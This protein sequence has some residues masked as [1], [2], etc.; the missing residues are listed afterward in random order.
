MSTSSEHSDELKSLFS[1]T[2][3]D[4]AP[5]DRELLAALR[6]HSAAE[7]AQSGPHA[8][9]EEPFNSELSTEYSVPPTSRPTV[10]HNSQFALRVVVAVAATA[11][12][13]MAGFFL[14]Q[15]SRSGA[16]P[17]AE[18]TFGEVMQNLARTDSYRAECLIEDRT[19]EIT[20]NRAQVMRVEQ[21]PALYTFATPEGTLEVDEAE[22]RAATTNRPYYSAKLRMLDPLSVWGLS[23]EQFAAVQPT[24]RETIA[25]REHLVYQCAF[26]AGGVGGSAEA[27][28]DV[29]TRLPTQIVLFGDNAERSTLADFRF[30]A[31]NQPLDP[32]KLKVPAT[33]T[34]DGRIGKVIDWQGNVALRPLGHTRWTPVCDKPLLR[35]GDWVRTDFQGANAVTVQLAPDTK[36]ILGPGS[37][38]ELAKPDQ[39]TLHAGFAEITPAPKADNFGGIVKLTGP[40]NAKLDVNGVTRVTASDKGLVT[41]DKEP[42]WLAAYKGAAVSESL[43]SLVATIDGRRVPLTVGYH[44]VSVEIRDQI[45]RT[46]IEESF[47]NHTGGVLEGQFHFPL[48]ADASISGFGM[49]VDGRLVEADIVEKQ[50]AREIYETILREKRDPGLLEWAGGNIFK[51]RVYPIPAHGEKRIKIVYTQVLPMRG[52]SYRY[53]YALQSDLLK[54]NPLRQLDLEVTVASTQPLASVSCPTHQTRNQLTEHAAR[55]E[56]SAQNYTPTRDFEVVVEMGSAGAASGMAAAQA[57][58]VVFIPHQRGEDGYF[59]LQLQPPLEGAW[60]RDVLPDS[61]ALHLLVL[62]DTSASMDAAARRTQAEVLASL[63]GSLAPKDRFNLAMCD[64]DCTWLFTEAQS[65]ADEKSIATARDRLAKRRSLGWTNLDRA[66]EAVAG[67]VRQ[68]SQ[69]VYLGDGIVTTGDMDGPAFASRLKQRLDGRGA[70]LHAVALSSSYDA[71]VLRGMAAIGGGSLRQVSGEIGPQQ[72]A[73]NLLAE[74]TR[75]ALKNIELTISGIQTAHVYPRVLPNL[76]AGT[77]QIVLGRYLPGP[78]E[79]SG[80]II[81]T[82]VLE[83]Q[84]VTYRTELRVQGSGFRVQGPDARGQEPGARGQEPGARNQ[85]IVSATPH[86]AIRTPQ[87]SDSSFIPRLWARMHLDELLAQGTTQEIQDEII[88]LSEEF[89]I[90]TPYTSLLVLES[91]AD[92]ERFKVKR[93][94]QIRDGERFF[95][96]ARDTAQYQLMQQQMQRAGLWRRGL[97]EQVLM[98]LANFGRDAEQIATIERREHLVKELAHLTD[99]ISN[100][101]MQQTSNGPLDMGLYDVELGVKIAAVEDS[102]GGL[103]LG[104]GAGGVAGSTIARGFQTGDWDENGMPEG[105]LLISDAA[106]AVDMPP[107]YAPVPSRHVA[108]E[109]AEGIPS[110]F[111]APTD[112]TIAVEGKLPWATFETSRRK[113]Q[114]AGDAIDLDGDF[115][116]RGEPDAPGWGTWG[117]LS[118][119]TSAGRSVRRPSRGTDALMKRLW[120]YEEGYLSEQSRLAPLLP[121]GLAPARAASKPVD[122]KSRWPAEAQE[123][124]RSLVTAVDLTRLDGGL[125][126]EEETRSFHPHHGRLTSLTTHSRLASSKAWFTRSEADGYDPHLEWARGEERGAASLAYGVELVR[127]A[128]PTDFPS[129][130]E[131]SQWWQAGIEWSFQDHTVEMKRPQEGQ[132]ELALKHPVQTYREVRIAIDAAKKVVLSAQWLQRGKVETTAKASDFIEIAGVWLPR[133]I[134]SLDDRGRTTST[135]TRKFTLVSVEQLAEKMTAGLAPQAAALRVRLRLP[136][137]K[138]AKDKIALG[139][140]GLE[141]RLVLLASLALDQKW[142]EAHAELA[143][144][145]PLVAD[146]SF[147]KWLRIWLLEHSRRNE[148]LRQAVAAE[149]AKLAENPASGERTLLERLRSLASSKFSYEEQLTV[150]DALKPVYARLPEHVEGPRLWGEIRQ[151]ILQNAGRDAEQLALL[152]ELVRDY[153]AED[154]HYRILAR[155]LIEQGEYDAGYA[156]LQDALARAGANWSP[157]ERDL[158]YEAW[159]DHLKEQGRWADVAAVTAEWLKHHPEDSDA[160]ERHIASLVYTRREGEA[161]ALVAAWLKAGLDASPLPKHVEAQVV[162]AV[163]TATGDNSYMSSGEVDPRSLAAMAQ[164][165]LAHAADDEEP[166]FLSH[167]SSDYEVRRT[168]EYRAAAAKLLARLKAE[169][170]TLPLVQLQQL[171]AW[172]TAYAEQATDEDW[173]AIAAA[174]KPRWQAASGAE[175]HP[176]IEQ[177]LA[178]ALLQVFGELGHS[179]RTRFLRERLAASDDERR[180]GRASALFHALLDDAWSAENEAESLALIDKLSAS[181]D[182]AERLREAVAALYRWTDRMESARYATLEAAIER[183]DKLT[184]TELAA[185]HTELRKRVLSDLADRLGRS[186]ALPAQAAAPL[187]ARDSGLARWLAIERLTLEARLERELAKV[188]ENAWELL[189]PVPAAARTAEQPLMT[190]D[191]LDAAFRARTLAMLM[192]LAI[193]TAAPAA[194]AERLAKYLDAAIAAEK[195]GAAGIDARLAKYVLLVALDKPQPLAEQ[196]AIWSKGTDRSEFWQRT[197]GYLKA[198]L[199]DLDG[200][201]GLFEPLAAA[202]WLEAADYR[203]L[204]GWHQVKRHDEKYQAAHLAAWK[205]MNEYQLRQV[206]RSHVAQWENSQGPSPGAIDPQLL[207]VL[208]ALFA[209]S[210]NPAEHVYLVR[211]LYEKSRDFRLLASLAD[212]VVG[213][214][215]GNI[216]RFLKELDAA[217]AT[218]DREAT[219]DEL[220]AHVAKVRERVALPTGTAGQASSATQQ[221]VD[222]RALDLLTMFA[223]QRA[224]ELQNQP[225]PHVVAAVAALTSATRPEWSPGEP[226]LFA[227]LLADLGGISQKPLSDERLR[228]LRSLH[229]AAAGQPEERLRIAHALAESLVADNRRPEAL[230]VLEPALAEHRA[231]SGGKL[232]WSALDTLRL[233][234]SETASAG[235]Y[236]RAEAIYLTDL[237]RAANAR[238]AL[239]IRLAIHRVHSDAIHADA[240]TSLGRGLA[241]Y[242]AAER[243]L[244]GELE[245]AQGQDER[246]R[247][248]DRLCTLYDVAHRRAP[249]AATVA[250]DIVRFGDESLPA[251]L[252]KQIDNYQDMVQQ[253]ERT[254]RNTAGHLPA[255]RFLVTRIEREPAWL[256]RRGDDGWRQFAWELG[257]LHDEVR[258]KLGELEPRL[259]SIVLAALRHDLTLQSDRRR[260]LYHRGS[261]HYWHER[262]ADFA[263]VAEEVLAER[264]ESISSIRYIADYLYRGVDRR[265]RAI[266][267]LFDAHRRGLLDEDGRASLVIWLQECERFGESVALLESLTRQHPASLSYRVQLVRAYHRSQQPAARDTLLAET[268]KFFHEE[269]RWNENA[270]AELAMITLECQLHERALE[271]LKEAIARRE[272]ALNKQTTGDQTLAQYYVDRAYAYAG[273]ASTT[274]AVDDACSVAVIW[275]TAGDGLYRR[276]FGPGGMT[277]EKVHPLDVLKHVLA[278]SPNLDAYVAQ[279]DAIVAKEGTDRPIVRKSLGE[280]YFERKQYKAAAAQLRLAVEL[281]PGD[282]AIHARL[283]ECYDALMQSRQ[284]AEQL[285]ASVELARRDVQLWAKLAERLEKLE[286]PV[287][288]ERARTS[289]VE[290]LPHETEG[291]TKLAEIRQAQDRWSDAIDH[292]RHVARLRKL[293]P[294]GLVGLAAAQI[295]LRQRAEADETLRE[296][297]TTRWDERFRKDLREKELPRLREA[298]RKLP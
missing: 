231:A 52:D 77:Q 151:G 63:L 251:L 170:A 37:L 216:Y 260:V 126:V 98:S 71:A 1:A 46:T 81:V 97:R 219:V 185:K 292:W 201:I 220:L 125:V 184:R 247:L 70:T 29:A 75:P 290:M 65:A 281:S 20:G 283:V 136:T 197:L 26:S 221:A 148:E 188:V 222:A 59:L 175:A 205:Q 189:G 76:P 249:L 276:R 262:E 36:L 24:G 208:K 137:L 288:A 174:I 79:Q 211:N 57:S 108:V 115:I 250:A 133:K 142:P 100:T 150:L 167:I 274:A 284:A 31:F 3:V 171:V 156:V 105:L 243:R 152:R 236:P 166:R 34:E 18:L 242:Q 101:I 229:A 287:E 9:R 21:S 60:Q 192:R 132:I 177:L 149:A 238:V 41:S 237:P 94:F 58:E 127:K 207:L 19:F 119:A 212:A 233:F 32:A 107:V 134:E 196:L 118:G 87:S 179:E 96:D 181:D 123:L 114:F 232:A 145:E 227:Q 129:T 241:L 255:L 176:A 253:V 128:E 143:L 82:G 25:G 230:D 203:A 8:H 178:G 272:E 120:D 131:A 74:M 130:Y 113:Q 35:M 254:I 267:V 245:A 261:G 209:K 289:L 135:I 10:R 194:E 180:A 268:D 2:A 190:A 282:G 64:V 277:S 104:Q 106:L 195:T 91:D 16:R 56:F 275:G 199:G 286:E 141:E 66:F 95:A 164:L 88:N 186:L 161:D 172:C 244:I 117:G 5:P 47:V 293:E 83:G 42:K 55:V 193:R 280:V 215:A 225:G 218:I 182:P 121:I 234:G 270:A 22:N 27:Y 67:K 124:S 28:V 256:A 109:F 45:A 226:R 285:F 223:E 160:Y 162:A 23:S 44:K 258:G 90:I 138:T 111:N 86:S 296:L 140:A 39:L 112:G 202:D 204:A 257:S 213:Q 33:L 163:E 40:S 38:L 102:F 291:H 53:T 72:T 295:H 297:E 11:A 169:A 48:P 13:V 168:D 252:D 153:P 146:K 266:E 248:V 154:Y 158:L 200:A 239:E 246:R 147:A 217:L 173:Q 278:E 7:F 298:W 80:E 210:N 62:V 235:S 269:D 144:I 155:R 15:L 187:A 89:H 165:L 265:N 110:W 14:I 122:R 294:A 183:P 43:G 49:W 69:V 54:Q 228:V 30:V 93:R 264:R 103:L 206:V 85:E 116:V 159:A 198:E 61:E 259:L 4:A 263:R 12:V 271:Y 73:K 50:R 273:L 157:R 92:R 191:R 17:V 99:S 68:G 6:E 78:R 240:S 139:Q 224:A 51:A 279:L 84:P 214:S